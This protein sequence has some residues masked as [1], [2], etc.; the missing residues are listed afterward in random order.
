MAEMD[1]KEGLQATVSFTQDLRSKIIEID[2]KQDRLLEGYISELIEPDR[3][4][5]ENNKLT[6]ERK[7]LAE[8]KVR[9]EQ[10]GNSWLEPLR[11][12]IKDAQTL[13]EI[14]ETTPGPLKKSFAQKIFGSNLFLKNQ[15]IEYVAQTQYAELCSA[16]GKNGNFPTCRIVAHRYDLART[17]FIK[18]S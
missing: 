18:N 5:E 13:N 9:L 15:K 1:E 8:Q 6:S 7:T 4:R 3:Y 2:R 16:Y 14:D 10:K 11:N 17:E 12:W